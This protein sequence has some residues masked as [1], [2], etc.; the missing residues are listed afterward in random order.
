MP[1]TISWNVNP[2]KCLSS[3]MNFV[4]TVSLM[5]KVTPYNVW[6]STDSLKCKNLLN[7]L[8]LFEKNVLLHIL[9]YSCLCSLCSNYYYSYY[10]NIYYRLHHIWF[11]PWLIHFQFQGSFLA[12][13]RS[14][15]FC[16]DFKPESLKSKV[17][18]L[19]VK[20]FLQKTSMYFFIRSK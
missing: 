18:V 20:L 15:I 3:F 2:Y 8:Q 1:Y 10:S 16:K 7:P 13:A 12:N 17:S 14:Y 19:Q 9:P 6:I 5:L 11:C 4:T